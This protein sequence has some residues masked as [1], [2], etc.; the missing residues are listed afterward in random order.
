MF[1]CDHCA[2]GGD[3]KLYLIDEVRSKSNLQTCA[4]KTSVCRLLLLAE[5]RGIRSR[6]QH[7]AQVLVNRVM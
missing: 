7:C 5:S 2:P 3:N 6:A 1:V 4:N